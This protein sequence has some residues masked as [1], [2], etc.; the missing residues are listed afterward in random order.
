M[1]SYNLL[2]EYDYPFFEV[3]KREGGSMVHFEGVSCGPAE[4]GGSWLTLTLKGEGAKGVKGAKYKGR[5]HLF[6]SSPKNEVHKVMSK[7]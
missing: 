5:V 3:C 2:I 4:N 1:K 6:R 7:R